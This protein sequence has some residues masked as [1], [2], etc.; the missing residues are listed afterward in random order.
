M[1][2]TPSASRS[3]ALR[4]VAAVALGTAAVL[5][6]LSPWYGYH[7]DELYFRLLGQDPKL[8]Y[9]DT[10]P[11]TP[12][13]A[14]VSTE[15]FGDNLVALRVIPALYTAVVILLV[16]LITSE[17]GGS[18][19]AQLLAVGG[20]ATSAAVLV[21]GHSLLTAGPDLAFWLA[22]ILFMLRALLR[23]DGR[24]WLAAGAVAGAA[25]YNRDLIALLLVT[26]GVGLLAA[27]P[28]AVLRD[29]NLWLGASLAL[30]IALPNILW[31]FGHGWPEV[32]MSQALK[33]D[34]GDDNRAVFVPLQLVLIGVPQAVAMVAG[35]LR[36]WRDRRVRA[37]AVAYPLAAVL[38]LYSGGRADYTVGLLLLMYAAG[39]VSAAE[40]RRRGILV[41]FLVVGAI[42]QLIIGLPLIPVAALA[43][44]PV[45]AINEVSRESV[46]WDEFGTQV[47]LVFMTLPPDSVLV[48][49]NYGEA[50]IEAA[51]GIGPVYSA[52]NELY[53]WGPPPETARTALIVTDD[54][55]SYR[56]WFAGCEERGRIDNGVGVDNEE[57]GLAITVCHDPVEPWA[58]I[59]PKWRHY[60]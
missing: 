47:A 60:S 35:W 29:R 23:G 37:L 45:P 48:A 11:L 51:R 41:G 56:R 38:V 4:P 5:L 31:Q 54:P 59:W 17:L 1:V 21:F 13:I 40:W 34:E 25:T 22:A 15:I 52:H 12:M 33:I 58:S 36:L 16:G 28:R 9:F 6:A 3:F 32:Q 26:I 24:W 57:Q 39:C 19:T 14:R 46:G 50:G 49:E 44:T 7:R 2:E 42:G 53:W 30:V 8:G 43:K 18:R 27:G 55:E 10:P 20:T